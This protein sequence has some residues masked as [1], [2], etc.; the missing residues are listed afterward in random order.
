F[1]PDPKRVFDGR[2]GQSPPWADLAALTGNP[3]MKSEN[4]M[5]DPRGRVFVTSGDAYTYQQ[6]N[7]GTVYRIDPPAH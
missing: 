5:V 2:T 7:G 6:G 4:V 1:R 3:R